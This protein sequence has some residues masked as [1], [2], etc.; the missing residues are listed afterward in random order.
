MLMAIS[1][2]VRRDLR[3]LNH[4]EIEKAIDAIQQTSDVDMLILRQ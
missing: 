4:K 1:F 3:N 2:I